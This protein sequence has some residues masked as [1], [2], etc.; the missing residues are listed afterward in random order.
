MNAIGA[1]SAIS[2]VSG[3]SG[4][5]GVSGTPGLHLRRRH[6]SNGAGAVDGTAA[7]VRPRATRSSTR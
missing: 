4:I 7:G 1:I 6:S 2:G 5:S 3:V